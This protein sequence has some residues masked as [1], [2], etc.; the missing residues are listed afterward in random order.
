MKGA[1]P[2]PSRMTAEVEV[3]TGDVVGVCMCSCGKD[4]GPTAVGATRDARAVRRP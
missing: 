2:V 3:S 4:Y 1:P